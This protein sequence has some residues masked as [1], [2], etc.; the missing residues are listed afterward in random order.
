MEK[1]KVIPFKSIKKIKR[2]V[3]TPPTK[4][5]FEDALQSDIDNLCLATGL[6]ERE[7]VQMADDFYQKYPAL[8]EHVRSVGFMTRGE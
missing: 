2:T 3:A 1:T 7:A 5:N 4:F 8:I 6:G